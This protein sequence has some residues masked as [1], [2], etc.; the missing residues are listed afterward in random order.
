[1]AL[2]SANLPLPA[3]SLIEITGGDEYHSPLLSATRLVTLPFV[4]IARTTAPRPERIS[5]VG[6]DEY[7]ACSVKVTDSTNSPDRLAVALPETPSTSTYGG[8]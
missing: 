5:T 2:N 7:C 4:T 8:N 3:L 6:V 1:M